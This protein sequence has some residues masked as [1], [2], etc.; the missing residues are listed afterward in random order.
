VSKELDE[1]ERDLGERFAR[2]L[3]ASHVKLMEVQEDNL[4]S[5]ALLLRDQYIE[6]LQFVRS[7]MEDLAMAVSR[8]SIKR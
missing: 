7:E 1:L 4:K 3:H 2:A 8:R 5:V 6:K